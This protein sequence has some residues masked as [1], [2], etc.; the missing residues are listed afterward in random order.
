MIGILVVIAVA[1]RRQADASPTLPVRIS[2][3]PL[4]GRVKRQELSDALAA[5]L[6]LIRLTI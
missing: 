1:A 5:F 3:N 4:N 6:S 2:L